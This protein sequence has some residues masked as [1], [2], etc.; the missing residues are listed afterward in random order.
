MTIDPGWTGVLAAIG[1]LLIPVGMM[2][3]QRIPLIRQALVAVIRMTV[4]LLLVGFYLQWVFEV[5]RWWVTLPWLVVMV[6]TATVSTLRGSGLRARLLIAAAGPALLLG[7]AIPLLWF[8]GLVLRNPNVLEARYAIPVGGMILGNCLRANI[9]GIRDFYQKIRKDRK[10]YLLSLARGATLGEAVGPY[11]RES[12]QAAI[13]P[14]IA[15]MMT[16][17]VVSVPG[18]MT[19]VILGGADPVVAIRYQIGIML[20]IFTGTS[21]TVPL[22][23]YFS[24]RR[25]FDGYGLLRDDVFR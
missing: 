12:F 15:T 20:A 21:I 14:T 10:A 2:V 13:A 3:Y 25:C 7:T 9:V 8:I 11:L 24:L 17:G 4:Q 5:D 16:V 6:S 1:M 18:M 19:G 22:A 23:I